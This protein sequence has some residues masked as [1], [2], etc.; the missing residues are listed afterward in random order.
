[1]CIHVVDSN[2]CMTVYRV[3]RFTD[4]SHTPPFNSFCAAQTTG[5]QI[6][7]R[8]SRPH[9]AT[10]EQSPV[11][12]TALRASGR[13]PTLQRWWTKSRR[14]VAV[15]PRS[16]SFTRRPVRYAPTRT[17]RAPC[18]PLLVAVCRASLKSRR[19]GQSRQ[20]KRAC[21]RAGANPTGP[22]FSPRPYA[23]STTCEREPRARPWARPRERPR[24]WSV[25]P[26]EVL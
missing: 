23:D 13:H 19:S 6:S 5:H 11:V 1:M 8:S 9:T 20:S 3:K 21:C 14:K 7:G 22:N 2:V 10:G 18:A 26:V 12:R 24:P 16:S 17:S 25:V 4:R 15:P